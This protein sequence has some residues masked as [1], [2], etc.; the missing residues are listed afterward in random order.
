MTATTQQRPMHLDDEQVQRVLHGELLIADASAVQEHIA[1]CDACRQL[2]ERARGEEAEILV[3]LGAV[4]HPRRRIDIESVRRIARPSAASR[5]PLRW[6]AGIVAAVGIAGVAYAVPASPLK[7]WIDELRQPLPASSVHVPAPA[8]LPGAN[9]EGVSI[10]PGSSVRIFFTAAQAS[11]EARVVLADVDE[12]SVRTPAGSAR[13]AVGA[14]QLTIENVGAS[15]DYDIVV[16]RSAP[17]VEILVAGVRIWSKDG[18]RVVSDYPGAPDGAAH[19]P[20]RR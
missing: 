8:A 19:L 16:P 9:V 18:E 17:R 4:D 12:I 20:L 10:A 6:A 11:G 1:S 7:R 2:I 3:L 5:L 13:F 14:G 15:V